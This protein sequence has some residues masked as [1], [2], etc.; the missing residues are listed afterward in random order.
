[1]T[2]AALNKVPGGPSPGALGE[3]SVL[4]ATGTAAG[5]LL[6]S[7]RS[8][9]S[10]LGTRVVAGGMVVATIFQAVGWALRTA[11]QG[12]AYGHLFAGTMTLLLLASFAALGLDF[13]EHIR[14]GRA[15]LISDV[16]LL[17]TVAGVAVFL[18]LH[19]GSQGGASVWAFTL[20][21]VITSLGILVLVG[22]SVLALWCPTPIH[23]AL[24]ACAVALG[25]SAII[26]GDARHL[27]WSVE[28]TSGP[29]F[30]AAAAIVALTGVLV[31]EP[32]L[33]DGPPR[34]PAVVPW[35]RPALMGVSLLG[36]CGLIVAALASRD[37]RLSVAESIAVTLVVLA[38]VGLRTLINQIA[39]ARSARD[40]EGALA[41]REHAIDSLRS[42]ATVVST[43]EARLRLLLDAAVDG[44]VELD[45][46]GTIMRANGAFSAMVHLPLKEIV[47]RRWP[48]MVSRSIRRNESLMEL[49]KTGEA[50][51]TD[52][53][54]TSY[55]EARASRLPTNPPGVLLMIRDV[56]A[57]KTAEQTIRTLF[58]YLQDRD[59]D[60]T[61]LLQRTN[62]AIEAERNRIAR[63]LHDGPI[64]GISATVLS[65]EAVKLMLAGSTS[66]ET[67]PALETLRTIA[68]ELSE[69]AMNLRRVMSDLRPPV[70]EERGLIPA[71]RELADRSSR[72]LGIAVRVVAGDTVE[73][74]SDIETLAYR[75]VQEALSNV[76]KH[77]SAHEVVVRV[78]VAAGQLGVEV[79]DDGVGFDQEDV[80]DFLRR[81]KVGLASMR[82][83]AELAG[84]TLTV[85]SEPGRGTTIVATLPFDVLGT[86]QLTG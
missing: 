21:A 49:P 35:L 67:L 56:T 30:V 9:R 10:W 62:A 19:Q 78:E 33:N 51:L 69:E 15:E 77:A 23:T 11:G 54:G 27:H 41:Q 37:L 40:L 28:A 26:L 68:D 31:I 52:D 59:E 73:M 4:L 14:K 81:G 66:G 83:R 34:P 24:F 42:A 82:E 1:V 18:L 5:T 53:V 71:V 64:Q 17:S 61:R 70:L 38:A 79:R 85:K 6:A 50:L 36:A 16:V 57:S 3:A 58:Q 32:R 2:L 8:S 60:R 76:K 86:T 45:E 84:G 29:E 44:V 74:A 55:L 80:R 7:A 20:T 43:S 13:F 47:G 22:W 72:D 65:L 12:P 39:M 25:G 48:D 75:V 46:K 63:D